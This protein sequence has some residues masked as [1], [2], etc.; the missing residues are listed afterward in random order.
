M[1]ERVPGGQISEGLEIVASIFLQEIKEKVV[2]VKTKFG[3]SFLGCLPEEIK[4]KL[5][6]RCC[7]KTS[8]GLTC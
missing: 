3:N 1:P 4:W 5:P 7:V 6:T 2:L 8:R